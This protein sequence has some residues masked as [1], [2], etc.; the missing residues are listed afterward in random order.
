[1]QA[2]GV[3][4]HHGIQETAAHVI[5]HLP[6]RGPHPL[7]VRAHVVVEAALGDLPPLALDQA[8]TVLDLPAHAQ[9]IAVPVGGD[10]RVDRC[11]NHSR[12]IHAH[13]HGPASSR[14]AR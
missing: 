12:N 3:P 4:H 2:I 1:V 5:E 7:L 6:I 14:L 9:Q 11:P 10:A 8:L 13:S